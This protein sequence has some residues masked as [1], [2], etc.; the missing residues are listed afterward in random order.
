MDESEDYEKADEQLPYD[1]TRRTSFHEMQED[2]TTNI[3]ELISEP[4][5]PTKT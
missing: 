3:N 4:N 1:Q 2:Y 5:L